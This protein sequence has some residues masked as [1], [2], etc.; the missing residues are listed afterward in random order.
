MIKLTKTISSLTNLRPMRVDRRDMDIKLD[1]FLRLSIDG[2]IIDSKNVVM[3]LKAFQMEEKSKIIIP[4]CSVFLIIENGGVKIFEDNGIPRKIANK[5][6]PHEA[7]VLR[8]MCRTAYSS[9]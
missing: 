4:G 6:L 5:L 3:I 8:L 9:P 2:N 7:E 1:Q